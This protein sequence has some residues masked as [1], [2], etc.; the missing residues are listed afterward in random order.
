M[1]SRGGFILRGVSQS[2][3]M[4]SY[5]ST[6]EIFFGGYY[7]NTCVPWLRREFMSRSNG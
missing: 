6:V 5:V 2:M 3:S 1:D 7:I 4:R